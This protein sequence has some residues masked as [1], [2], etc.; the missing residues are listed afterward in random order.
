MQ[1]LVSLVFV[2]VWLRATQ[3]V[4]GSPA[5]PGSLQLNKLFIFYVLL[6]KLSILVRSCL[7]ALLT[8]TGVLRL[9]ST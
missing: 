9:T 4:Q 6:K 8:P 2:K 7:K 1:Q 5:T 3:A